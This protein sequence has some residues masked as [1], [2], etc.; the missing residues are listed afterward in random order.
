MKSP[1]LLVLSLVLALILTSC[2]EAAEVSAENTAKPVPA[3]QPT[4]GAKPGVKAKPEAI[5]DPI[6]KP[7]VNPDAGAAAGSDA[8]S[9]ALSATAPVKASHVDAKGAKDL[10]DKNPAIV[11]I[12]V[13]TE[14]EFKAGHVKGG[15]LIDVFDKEF[16]AKVGKL[17]RS[18][19]YLV[20]CKVGGRS[21]RALATFEKLGFQQVVHM[22]GGFDAWKAAGLPVAK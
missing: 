10:L 8:V 18:K 22:D 12:D 5:P 9:D 19:T 3:S 1:L 4:L 7:D 13:R 20:H 15:A 17:D 2:Q 11:V 14:G 21:T 16:A 6:A